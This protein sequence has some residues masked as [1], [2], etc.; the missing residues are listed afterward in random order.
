MFAADAPVWSDQW[1]FFA[2][3]PQDVLAAVSIVLLSLLIIWWRQQSSHWFRITMLTLLAALGM[4]I[5]SYYFFEVPVYHAN[6]PAGCAGWRGFPLRFA[7]IDLRHIT[8]LA[9]GDFA[10]NV[11]TLWLLWLVASVIW[12]LLAMVLHWEQRSWRSQALF[13]VVAA[14]L[15]WALTPR[16]VNPPEPHITG[17]PARLAINARRAAEFTYDITG[18]W[19]Q[20]LALEDVR[21]LDPNADPTPDAVNR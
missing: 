19:V 12:R 10:M 11:L 13:I 2:S 4:S 18:L 5:G 3:W 21:L 9:P 6:C 15:P 7:V 8:Y 16:F 17:E 14:I 1:T 20:R